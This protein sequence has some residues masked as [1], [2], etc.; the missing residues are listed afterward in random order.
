MV[1][2]K[3]YIDRPQFLQMIKDS[4]NGSFD[5]VLVYKT[6]HFARNRYDD[7]AVYKSKLKRNSIKISTLKK[8]FLMALKG[9]YWNL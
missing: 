8:I 5:A 9:L 2:I 3:H 1:I 7:S 6:D 4:A